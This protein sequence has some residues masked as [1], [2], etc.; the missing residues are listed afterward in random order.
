[1]G[2]V[3]SSAA[4][5]LAMSVAVSAPSN[6]GTSVPRASAPLASSAPSEI[7]SG[8]DGTWYSVPIPAAP[9]IGPA[10]YH[11][12]VFDTLHQR[13]VIFAGN[14]VWTHSIG[15]REAWVHEAVAGTPPP[16]RIFH[17]AI[18]DPTGNRM[19]IFGGSSFPGNTLLNDLWQLDF[20]TTPPTWSMVATTG[21]PP[22][23]REGHSA[24]FDPVRRR[25]V[26][27]GGATSVTG[28]GTFENATWFL[29]LTTSPPS[30]QLAAVNGPLP[31]VR[32]N[33][34]AI[35]DT[36]Q[37]RMVIYGGIGPPPNYGST[38]VWTL[39]MSS[40]TWSQAVASSNPDVPYFGTSTAYDPV[41]Q[42]MF[43]TGNGLLWSLDLGT[44]IWTQWGSAYHIGDFA[45]FA[46]D[47]SGHHGIAQGG[48]GPFNAVD[49]TWLLTVDGDP[50]WSP[51]VPLTRR[52]EAAAVYDPV[53]DRFMMI[54]GNYGGYSF[55]DLSQLGIGRDS[56]WVPLLSSTPL[57]PRSGLGAVYDP[58][59]DRVIVFGGSNGAYL[60]DTWIVQL[61]PTLTVTP[62]A[63][64][65]APPPARDHF[66]AIY[67]PLR[68]RIVIDG[69]ENGSSFGD[70]WV[71]NL[72]P[73]LSWSP[74]TPAPGPAPGPRSSHGVIYDPSGDRML[75]FGGG[76]VW[77]LSLG[78]SPTWTPLS[79]SG[80]SGLRSGVVFDPN[81]QR[82]LLFGSVSDNDLFELRL[83]A[84][85]L[86]WHQL[87]PSGTAPGRRFYHVVAFDAVHDRMLVSGGL[88]QERQWDDVWRLQFS[89]DAVATAIALLSSDVR[90]DVVTLKWALAGDAATFARLE[91][92]DASH[93]WRTIESGAV[94]GS[95]V[96]FADRDVVA[97]ARYA[98]RL[99]AYSGTETSTSKE[100][101]IDL[102]AGPSFSLAG[103][104]P[105]PATREARVS[106]S[107]TE[108]TP[109]TIEIADVGGRRVASKRIDSPTLGAQTMAIAPEGA[110]APGLYF[111]RLT[112][113]AHTLSARGSVMR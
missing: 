61:S 66:A 80:T 16:A 34:H 19:L 35:F 102:P 97:G 104:S 26:V 70:D 92:R 65:G 52:Q 106:F 109:A 15:G 17:S 22:S 40:L 50:V 23:P 38:D 72:S 68:D 75:V 1:M 3:L 78:G 107:L 12:M 73:S 58:V 88:D 54:G 56:T 14:E 42:R 24:V 103:F 33:H 101:W 71:L 100:V 27:F 44:F 11:T 6:A 49:G 99:T 95:S 76:G 45:A 96:G 47:P 111:V 20:S 112:Q 64:T 21:T 18:D 48:E 10:S 13:F 59:R 41:G 31:S 82:A 2:R 63:V 25:M 87:S 79:P 43:V 94:S 110:L 46:I 29:D 81:R 7:T 37:D 67:D 85:P 30:W 84:Q 5:L 90:S 28:P 91:R 113:G 98:Y 60:N 9:D 53:R 105:N 74:I 77:A 86:A 93:D 51:G 55:S 4:I 69:G 108:R 8:A 57:G 32:A 39:P 83:G 36:V 89:S 62:A